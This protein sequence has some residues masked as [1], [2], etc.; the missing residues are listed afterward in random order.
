MTM[1]RPIHRRRIVAMIAGA[2]AVM[3]ATAFAAH[4]GPRP[5]AQGGVTWQEAEWRMPLDNWGQGRAWHT[6]TAGGTEVLLYART[7]TGF[8]NCF[9]GVADDTEIDRIGD[10]DLHGE[11]FTATAPGEVTSIGDLSGRKR[12]FQTSNRWSGARH[13][14]SIVAAT[15]CKAVVATIVS[16]EAISPG[17]E[18]SA[19]ALLTGDKFRRWAAGQ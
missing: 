14:L 6:T 19:V 10:V 12:S 9:N 4:L 17:A 8:C 5:Q 15:D 13:V 18:A 16:V 3:G 2:L 7:K 11:D 1:P